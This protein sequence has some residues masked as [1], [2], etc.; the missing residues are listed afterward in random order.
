MVRAVERVLVVEDDAVLLATL[1]R[2][3][4][5]RFADVRACRTIAEATAAVDGWT[6]GLIVVD[7]SLPDGDAR[8]ILDL[9][10]LHEPAPVVVAVSGTAEPVETF[11]LAQR[12]VRAY[13]AKPITLDELDQAIVL[14]LETAPALEPHLRQAVGHQTLAETSEQVRDVMI[15]EALART[16]GNRSGAARILGTTR[17]LLQYLL[18]RR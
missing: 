4:R 2:A 16:G 14:A 12:G 3:L 6:P 8:Q 10:G 18:R 15:D 1:E 5:R 11:E 7:F 13:L 17:Q 9:A